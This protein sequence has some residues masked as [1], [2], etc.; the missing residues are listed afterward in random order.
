MRCVLWDEVCSV[1]VMYYNFFFLILEVFV[2]IKLLNILVYRLGKAICLGYFRVVI[3]LIIGGE[4]R[5]SCCFVL[6]C[7]KIIFI[8]RFYEYILWSKY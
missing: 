5:V 8:C 2:F 6:D 7:F 3:L 4:G 1:L